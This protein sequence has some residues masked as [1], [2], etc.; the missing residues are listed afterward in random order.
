MLEKQFPFFSKIKWPFGHIFHNFIVFPLFKK[1]RFFINTKWSVK[2]VCWLLLIN[3]VLLFFTSLV[4][5]HCAVCNQT[6]IECNRQPTNY[7]STISLI[8][9]KFCHTKNGHNRNRKK[10]E[11]PKLILARLLENQ[12]WNELKAQKK[13][14]I[15]P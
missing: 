11:L 15:Y 3:N 4:C 8:S 7:F 2:M 13:E 1:L 5:V 12:R 6:L 14:F 10:C 9:F